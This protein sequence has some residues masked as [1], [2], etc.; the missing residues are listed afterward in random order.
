[1]P[2]SWRVDS[3]FT[4]D[5]QGVTLH[6]KKVQPRKHNTTRERELKSKTKTGFQP[7][8][9]FPTYTVLFLS[10]SSRT[11]SETSL[12]LPP[13]FKSQLLFASSADG[14]LFLSPNPQDFHSLHFSRH[15]TSVSVD[16]APIRLPLYTPQDLVSL[17]I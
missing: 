5:P 7:S 14:Q 16:K 15:V 1:M 13:L 12:F 6:R 8:T 4:R 11:Q 9:S 3:N 17:F 2:Y 10:Q